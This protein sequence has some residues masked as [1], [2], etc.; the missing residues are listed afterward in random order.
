MASRNH[1]I[2]QPAPFSNAAQLLADLRAKIRAEK[3]GSEA[4]LQQIVEAARTLTCADGA[5]IAVRREGSVVCMAR[6]GNKAPPLGSELQ[7]DSGISGQC[8]RTGEPLS[9]H[10]TSK[11]TRVDPEV[12]LGLGL[13]SLA[14]APVGK[15]PEVSGVLEI[16]STAP[17]AF[18]DNELQVLAELADLVEVAPTPATLSPATPS[19]VSD[20]SPE[21]AP[22]YLR[23]LSSA[24]SA[25]LKLVRATRKW[26]NSRLILAA[27][28]FFML[29]IWLALK[30]TAAHP[31]A[32]AASPRSTLR[33][34]SMPASSADVAEQPTTLPANG[35]SP[36]VAR[37]RRA[38]VSDGPLM[39][40]TSKKTRPIEPVIPKEPK[41]E[42]ASVENPPASA[43]NLTLPPPKPEV[44][45]ASPPPLV[46]S[47]SSN[48]VLDGILSPA[49]ASPVLAVPPSP[50]N[51]TGG[52]I[53]RLVQPTY[54][55]EALRLRREGRVILQAV[56]TKTGTVRDLKVI[57]GDLLLTRAAMDAVAQWRYRPYLVNGQPV[58][59]TTKITIVFN[60]P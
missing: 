6:A 30:G 36:V 26:S 38:S 45:V 5:A 24:L 22:R 44:D 60:L 9:C 4:M 41:S 56:I 48:P 15:W 21:V 29:V 16:F 27:A 18:N 54:P 51:I 19:T 28:A 23:I 49:T 13:R 46:V 11:D 31:S 52:T 2:T 59:K 33:A 34:S 37:D 25:G 1:E 39:A 12:C 20:A 57:D 42:T 40:S 8:M 53:E 7:V 50:T 32:S 3:P 55:P 43:R 58:Q 47:P 14:V 10:D 17:S 35:P